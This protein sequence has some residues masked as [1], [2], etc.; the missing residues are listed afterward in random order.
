MA[1]PSIFRPLMK[2]GMMLQNMRSIT[3]LHPGETM[4]CTS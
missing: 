4:S 3:Y 1:V 2:K